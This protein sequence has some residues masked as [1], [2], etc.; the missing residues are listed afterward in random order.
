[1]FT[2]F[3]YRSGQIEFLSEGDIPEGA[4]P[5]VAG[6]KKEVMDLIIATSR[7]AYDNKT[8]LVPGVPEAKSDNQAL[9]ALQQYIYWIAQRDEDRKFKFGEA[10]IQ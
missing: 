5:I 2:A 4:L 3:C 6:E 9:D 8:F 10:V 1:M 7:H